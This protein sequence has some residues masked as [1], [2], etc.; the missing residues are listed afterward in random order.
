VPA[1]SSLYVQDP[2]AEAAEGQLAAGA[3]V[4]HF[5]QG[6]RYPAPLA[7]VSLYARHCS[8]A[9]HAAQVLIRLHYG[10]RKLAQQSLPGRFH[11]GEGF[12]QP[13]DLLMQ[14]GLFRTARRFHASDLG[15][16]G[17]QSWRPFLH[18]CHR[19]D[20]LVLDL[21]FPLLQRLHFLLYR[22]GLLL[23]ADYAA[24]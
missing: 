7:S 11:A 17:R 19:L 14:R 24:V 4:L 10:R 8:A 3:G 1:C 9:T 12:P 21:P 20:E 15:S 18:L 22:A 5:A 23:L 6:Q 13:L 2:A 16:E